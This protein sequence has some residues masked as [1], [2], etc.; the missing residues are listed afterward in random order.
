MK[1]FGAYSV[2][3]MLQFLKQAGMEGR[4]N[5]AA[6]RARRNAVERLAPELTEAEQADLRC[7]DVAE[8][9]ARFH[10]LEGAS[11]RTETLSL[12]AER[13][14][15]GLSDFLAWSNDPM[16]FQSVG[17]ERRRAIARGQLDP[18][19]EVAER[20]SLESTRDSAGLIPIPLRDR[21]TVYIAN[22]PADLGREEAER[23]SRVIRAYARNDDESGRSES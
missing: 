14:Q 16:H 8:L 18:D 17:G 1:D 3:A 19:Q 21:V 9:A 10:K 23:I 6:A 20:I 4:I 7:L 11:I 12:Y 13:F 22:L 15:M 5:P 2:D